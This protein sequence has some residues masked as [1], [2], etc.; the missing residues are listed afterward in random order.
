MFLACV[1]ARY[2]DELYADFRQYYGMR[3][4]DCGVAERALLCAQL[5]IE[6]RVMRALIPDKNP[7]RIY[8]RAITSSLEWLVWAKTKDAQHGHGAPQVYG[9]APP[10]EP[11]DKEPAT[12]GLTIDEFEAL[13]ESKLRHG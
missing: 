6:S 3:P 1:Q 7:W 10:E 9:F 5:D 11:E 4:C 2:P 12:D 13:Y 8:L